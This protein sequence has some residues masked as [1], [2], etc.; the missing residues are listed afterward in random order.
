MFWTVSILKG[1]KHC[2]CIHGS[3][4]VINF[5]S[6]W[7]SFCL[8]NSVSVASQIL[9]LFVNLLTPDD[10]YSLSVKVSVKR[11]EFK[12]NYLIDP[13]HFVDIFLRFSNLHNFSNILKK[14][15]WVSYLMYFRNYT[16]QKA[17]LLEFLKSS[18][19]EHLWTVNMWKRPKHCPNLYGS[20]FLVFFGHPEGVSVRKILSS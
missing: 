3:T 8:R 15:R 20:R 10:K 5:W 1:R 18:V 14:K 17:W 6:L 7:K 19:L 16:R 2:W 13:K 4:F 9:R 11:K 12:R